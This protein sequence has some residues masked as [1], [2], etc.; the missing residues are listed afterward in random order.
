MDK[1]ASWRPQKEENVVYLG[2]E[3]DVFYKKY[4]SWFE[5]E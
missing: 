4:E 1:N 3:G 5:L 2:I